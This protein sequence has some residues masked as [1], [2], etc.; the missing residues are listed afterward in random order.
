MHITDS[1]LDLWG[2]SHFI[3]AYYF[4]LSFSSFCP[5]PATCGGNVSGPSGVILSPNY[6]QPYPAGKECDWRIRV[7]PD[8][9]IALIFKR[10]DNKHIFTRAYLA[11]GFIVDA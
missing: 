5:Y 6:P 9:V 11:P 3:S 4:F 2:H 7:N 1:P 10:L 8:F